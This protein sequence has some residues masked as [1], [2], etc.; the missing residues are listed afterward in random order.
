MRVKIL[1]V[2][3]GLVVALCGAEIICRL[4][5]KSAGTVPEA[6]SPSKVVFRDPF[7]EN[8]F[9]GWQLKPGTYQLPLGGRNRASKISVNADASRAT[10]SE[11]SPSF[12]VKPK[13]VFIGDSFTFGEGLDDEES[14]PW[15]LQEL[16]PNLNV[17]NHAVGGYGTCQAKLRLEQLKESLSAG[18]IVIY[19]FSA[20]HEERNTADPRLDYWAAMSS[21]NHKSGYPRCRLNGKEVIREDSKEWSTIMPLTGRSALSKIVTDTWLALLSVQTAKNQLELARALIAKMKD[22]STERGASLLVLLQDLPPKAKKNYR[23]FLEES[24][25]AYLDGTK[26]VERQDWKLPDGH[27]GPKITEQWAKSL[28]IIS[29]PPGR[30]DPSRNRCTTGVLPSFIKSL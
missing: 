16:L 21:P 7:V 1:L 8:L 5:G 12:S 6:F 10:R 2:V 20:F 3:F 29:F 19:G 9:T 13:I 15:R 17:I 22:I 14:L 18:D 28:S 25:I 26:V 4:A 11:D 23:D 24:Q 30:K 27:P